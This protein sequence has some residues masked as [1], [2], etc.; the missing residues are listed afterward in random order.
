V[1]GAAQI[2]I[3]VV[4]AVALFVSLMTSARWTS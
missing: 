3:Y 4:T 1:A 2:V